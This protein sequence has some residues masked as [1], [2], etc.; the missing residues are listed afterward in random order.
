[1]TPLETYIAQFSDKTIAVALHDLETGREIQI[2]ANES[3][4]P[5]STFK[6]HVMMEVFRQ[7]RDGLLALDDRLPLA[8]SFT[9]IA[10]GSKFSLLESDDAEQTLY[11]RLG[12]SESIGELTRLMIVR[13]SNLATNILIEKIRTENVN[14]LIRGLGI[15]GVTVRRGV[16]DKAAFGLHMN[17]NASARGLTQTMKLIAE[18][19]VVSQQASERMIEIMLAQEFNESIPALLPKAV[20]VAHKTGWTGDIYHDTGIVFPEGRKSYAIS[21]MTRGFAEDKPEDAHDCM[22]NV[23]KM[24]YEQ[25]Q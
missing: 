14:N 12:E 23:S 17:N 3:F 2:N 6:V 24:L 10:D 15:E 7:A 16:E 9:S 1:V 22:A 8:N 5:A 18:R 19:K 13:S 11:P 21:I 20:R 4:H 25:I